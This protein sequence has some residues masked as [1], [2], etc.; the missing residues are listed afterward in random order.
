MNIAATSSATSSCSPTAPWAGEK[1]DL[2]TDQQ[3]QV[4][5]LQER[6]REVRAHEAA[7]LSAAGGYATGSAQF[8]YSRGPD[9]RL[10]AIGGEVGID[11]SR[12]SDD[13]RATLTKAETIQRAALA[14]ADPSAQDQRVAAQAVAMATQARQEL[15][16][17]RTDDGR[18]GAAAEGPHARLQGRLRASGALPTDPNARDTLLHQ[19]A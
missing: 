12:V 13:P 19:V 18:A 15:A 2:S 16:Q 8:S 1:G 9:G 4:A 7:H 14:P 6:D 17:Q 10:Y 11:T 3:H 5:Q